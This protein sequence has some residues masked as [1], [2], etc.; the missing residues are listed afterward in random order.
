LAGVIFAYEPV[1][2]IGAAQP[3]HADHVRALATR[4]RR[5]FREPGV[6]DATGL[7]RSRWTGSLPGAARD[8]DGL[9]L[10]RSAHDVQNLRSVLA[11]MNAFTHHPP[12]A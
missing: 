7:R 5:W 9:F 12:D 11:K 8:I 1:W 4:L 6:A 10:G 2:A 3:A